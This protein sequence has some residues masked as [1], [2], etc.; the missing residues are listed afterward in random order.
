MKGKVVII[1]APSGSGKTTLVKRM[2]VSCPD[3]EFSISACTRQPRNNEK[4]GIDY[5]FLSLEKFELLI[6]QRAFVEF[7]MVYVGKYYGTLKSEFERIWN[8]SKA[9]M[10]DID[11]H[12][13]L[14]I[15]KAYPNSLTIFIQAP[16]IEVLRERLQQ[17]GT[18][19]EKSLQERVDKAVHEVELASQFDKVV[20][21]ED[22]DV[23][24]KEL[25]NIVLTY[26]K[27]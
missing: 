13:A 25:L 6:K 24:T 17:R 1:A 10:V 2:L 19:T 11:V 22:V 14:S 20:V 16:S 8:K 27:G 7:E 18:E 9:P 5:Y 26:L 15:K 23:A 12:G 4:E 21:N 3:L